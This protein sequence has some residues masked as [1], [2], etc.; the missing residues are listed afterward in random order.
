MIKKLI[1]KL[2]G[3][4]T[5]SADEGHDVPA[6]ASE[7]A[8]KPARKSTRKKAAAP[9]KR[10]PNVPVILSSEIH[11]I[12]PSLISKNAIRVTDGL[13][14]AGHRA[15]IVGGAVRDLLLGVAPKDFDVATD[16]TPDQVQK[17][18]RR[19]RII[20]RRFQIVHVQFGQEII[21]TSTFRALMDA[22]PEPS[23]EPP[24]RL[25]RGELDARTHAV[26]ASGRVLRD[27][28]WGE[29]HEDATR[30]DFTINAMYY[31]PATQTVLDYHDGMADIRARLLRMIGDPATRYREDPVRMLRVVR[32][33]AKLGFEIDEATR[34]PIKDLADLMNN[35]PAARLFDEM[36][37]L[38]LSGHALACL[39]RL[40]QEG[41][42]HGV[43]PLLDVVL[44]QPHGEK[45]V[46]LALTSTDERVRAGKGVSPGFLF[47]TLL[48]H[49]VQTRWQQY[50]ANG[51][52]PVPAL[53]RAMDDV[54]D[55]QT[56]KLAIHK[57]YSSDMREIWGLQ[58]RLEK[59]GR[60][61]LKLLEHQRFRAGYDFLLLRCESGELDAAIGQWWSDFID[62]DHAEREALLS[63][64]GK[65]RNAPKK[66]RRRSNAKR[67]SGE[68]GAQDEQAAQAGNDDAVSSAANR[69]EAA[70]DE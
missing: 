51:D 9:V 64:G 69:R 29:Q 15:F 67:R 11:G 6:A 52:Y 1:R 27:N 4:E 40:R 49:D 58:H 8:P 38:L 48:W 10:D 21:E 55:M 63:Q 68:P 28:V 32:F 45:F 59:R 16:A 25:K 19:A 53:H 5:A 70:D 12:D 14:Q 35:V 31:D 46:T 2:F 13:Q 22:P 24:R 39:T 50:T 20:G 57:R 42:H 26:D 66:R 60:S 30:R 47:A 37:K 7:A 34:A 62:G 61:A 43:L 18:F 23:A 36:L 41:L 44:E 3:Q 17:L 54:L 56:E 33:A 65:D